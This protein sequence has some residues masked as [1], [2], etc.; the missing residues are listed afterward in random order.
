MK[1][2]RASTGFDRFK[3][4]KP[5]EAII[6]CDNTCPR[7]GEQLELVVK[8]ILNT[9]IAIRY[10]CKCGY[11][12]PIKYNINGNKCTQTECEEPKPNP[13]YDKSIFEFRQ[14]FGEL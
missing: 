14:H 9:P 4:E 1:E 10:E 8:N 3:N 2:T 5:I 7:C 11:I 12:C 6:F 13:V